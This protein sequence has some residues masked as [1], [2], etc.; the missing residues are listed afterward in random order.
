MPIQIICSFVSQIF[1]CC[2]FYE[3][4]SFLK[5]NRS[6]WYNSYFIQFTHL[7][8]TIDAFII[9]T[10]CVTITVFMLECFYLFKMKFHIISSPS[11]YFLP[12]SHNPKQP[13]NPLSVCRFAYFGHF[14]VNRVIQYAGISVSYSFQQKFKWVGGFQLM[15]IFWEISCYLLRR[16]SQVSF[17]VGMT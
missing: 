15:W 16:V 17:K 11:L 12:N 3:S 9:L 13:R 14:Y 10:V 8:Y 2:V 4:Y 5:S 6:L 1:F 7:K